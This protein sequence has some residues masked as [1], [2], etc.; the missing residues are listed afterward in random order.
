MPTVLSG[1]IALITGASRGLGRAMAIS[2]SAAGA[3][4]ALVARDTEKLE[5]VRREIEEAFGGFKG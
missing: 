3:A 1:R 2:L 4:V 5:S